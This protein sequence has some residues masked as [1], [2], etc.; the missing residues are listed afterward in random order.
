M[1]LEVRQFKALIGPRLS[2]TDIRFSVS[3]KNIGTV[4]DLNNRSTQTAP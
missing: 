2:D 4:L 3:L 1:R